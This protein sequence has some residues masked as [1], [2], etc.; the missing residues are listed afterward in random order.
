MGQVAVLHGSILEHRR[1][2]VPGATE[3]AAHRTVAEDLA[4]GAERL[5][6]D[7][8]SRHALVEEVPLHLVEQRG[9]TQPAGRLAIS[10]R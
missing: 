7:H 4:R 10:R 2:A 3:P 9:V 8:D 6:D 1:E 5:F